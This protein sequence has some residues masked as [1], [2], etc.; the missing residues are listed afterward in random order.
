MANYPGDN[1]GYGHGNGQPG[2]SDNPGPWDT[3]PY[4]PKDGGGG[5]SGPCGPGLVLSE[6][7]V[8]GNWVG[9]VA[10]TQGSFLKAQRSAVQQAY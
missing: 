7:D 9:N 6:L 8:N 4:D 2:G 3:T 10:G 1:G 5:S